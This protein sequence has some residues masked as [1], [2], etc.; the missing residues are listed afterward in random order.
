MYHWSVDW[1]HQ[2]FDSLSPIIDKYVTENHESEGLFFKD[3]EFRIST[4]SGM[5]RII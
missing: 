1:A 3:F 2:T 4:N 5:T